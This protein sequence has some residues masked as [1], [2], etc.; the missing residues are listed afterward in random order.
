MSTRT[1]K[2]DQRYTCPPVP[3]AATRCGTRPAFGRWQGRSQCLVWQ[4]LQFSCRSAAACA[5]ACLH[6]ELRTHAHLCVRIA[7]AR[8]LLQPPFAA[9]GPQWHAACMQ[10]C[11]RMRARAHSAGPLSPA[12]V[13]AH[14]G[15]GCMCCV[16]GIVQR[17]WPAPAAASMRACHAST[18]Q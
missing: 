9:P 6:A 2:G 5:L 17:C 4:G 11:T 10:P 3:L 7:R 8:T 15:D 16:H 12:A 18:H 14:A 13:P 1:Q